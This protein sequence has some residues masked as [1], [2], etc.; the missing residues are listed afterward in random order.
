MFVARHKKAKF[1]RQCTQCGDG[2]NGSTN[3]PDNYFRETLMERRLITVA[4]KLSELCSLPESSCDSE[5]H[6]KGFESLKLLLC[7]W[8]PDNMMYCSPPGMFVTLKRAREIQTQLPDEF[9]RNILELRINLAV[10]TRIKRWAQVSTAVIPV[11]ITSH[12]SIQVLNNRFQLQH[13]EFYPRSWNILQHT[14]HKVHLSA[15]W[16]QKCPLPQN[17]RPRGTIISTLRNSTEFFEN[18]RAFVKSSTMDKLRIMTRKTKSLIKG[19]ST[20]D[21][22]PPEQTISATLPPRESLGKPRPVEPYDT[23]TLLS[24][25]E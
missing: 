24:S 17:P 8:M 2:M 18:R 12:H 1:L 20:V 22:L 23:W 6:K 15:L 3:R 25:G 10:L 13:I 14:F 5:G 19:K 11:W 16:T 7:R 21:L 9:Q 4:D